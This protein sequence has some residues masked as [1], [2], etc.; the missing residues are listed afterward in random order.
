[1][2]CPPDV[3]SGETGWHYGRY[4]YTYSAMSAPLQPSKLFVTP[5]VEASS[6]NHDS[7]QDPALCRRRVGYTHLRDHRYSLSFAS[8]WDRYDECI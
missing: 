6:L 1:M 7:K 8:Q 3:L 5:D 2:D 4:G